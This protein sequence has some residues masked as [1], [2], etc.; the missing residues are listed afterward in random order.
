[1]DV[2]ERSMDVHNKLI[3]AIYH[4]FSNI[5]L[6]KNKLKILYSQK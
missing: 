2:K 5:D 1:M 6:S 4:I 3:W